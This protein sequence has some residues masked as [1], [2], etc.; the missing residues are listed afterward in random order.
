MGGGNGQIVLTPNWKVPNGK[1]REKGVRTLFHNKLF[2]H[3]SW[4]EA[5][6]G[7]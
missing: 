4:L 5:R 7:I 1:S 6:V 3:L 2:V